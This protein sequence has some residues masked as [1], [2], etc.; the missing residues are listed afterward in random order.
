MMYTLGGSTWAGRGAP[1]RV[2]RGNSHLFV[3]LR[4]EEFSS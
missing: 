4:R 1:A 3:S 2:P